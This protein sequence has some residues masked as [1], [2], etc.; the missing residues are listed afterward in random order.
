MARLRRMSS[1]P[2][3]GLTWVNASP[4]DTPGYI[5]VRSSS[6]EVRQLIGAT[7][8]ERFV[9]PTLTRIVGELYLSVDLQQF[10][11]REGAVVTAGIRVSDTSATQGG[12]ISHPNY[13]WIWTF[14]AYCSSR[15]QQF[16]VGN[17]SGTPTGQYTRF[18]HQGDHFSRIHVDARAQRKLGVGDEVSLITSWVTGTDEDD[19]A[20]YTCAGYLRALIRE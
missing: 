13:D 10:L 8:L 14:G 20:T 7:A 3:R 9:D 17:S 18:Q 2:S 11:T 12:V 15:G 5:F 4:S 19:P 6:L 1:R 16:V